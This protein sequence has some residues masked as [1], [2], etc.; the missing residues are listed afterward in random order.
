MHKIRLNYAFLLLAAWAAIFS[1]P[2]QAASWA[3][4]GSMAAARDSHTATLLLNGKV[5]V[6]GG[7]NSSTGNTTLA[8]TAL[9]DPA[10]GTWTAGTMLTARRLH[11]ATLLLN[12]KVLVAGGINDSGPRA[13]AALYDPASG[14]WATTGAMATPRVGPTATLLPNGKVLVAG[15][16]DSLDRLIASAEVYDPATGTWTT[17]GGMTT[18]RGSHTATLLANGKVLVAGG[19]TPIFSLTFASAEVYDPASGTWTAIDNMTR[20]R[21]GHTATRLPNG[22][23]LVAGGYQASAEIYD[24]ASGTWTA[25]GAMAEARDS[26]TATLLPN[27]KVLVA[28]GR[29]YPNSLASAAVYN[30][31]SGTWT[32]TAAMA[33]PRSSH[34]ATLL[35]NGKVL[36]AG[37]GNNTDHYLASAELYTPDAAPT[38]DFVVTGVTLTPTSPGVNTAFTAKVTVK[39]QGTGAGNGGNL[40]VWAD[41]GATQAC[42]VSGDKSVAVGTLAAGASKTLAVAGLT[43]SSAG[44]KTLRIFVDG[45]CI[46]LESDEG[47]N[48]LAAS[49]RAHGPPP[50]FIVSAVT[51][52]PASPAA[53]SLFTATVK[54]TNQGTLAADAGFLDVWG[55][56][57]TLQP[58]GADGDAWAAVGSVAAGASKTFT[59]TLQAGTAGAKTLRAFVDSWCATTESNEG[60]NQSNQAYTVK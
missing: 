38:A 20:A 36:V 28:G 60:N 49:Y 9:Y 33:G 23:L 32:A 44:L 18:G 54:I 40:L 53:N 30:P 35:T 4:T 5:L 2:A 37:G 6:A 48:Q 58:C 59:L 7:L 34:T 41:Q 17:T 42:G 8:S 12:G 51:L 21:A 57:P 29:N 16:S 3:A 11:T 1:L 27:G 22:K 31:A 56:Q 14:T 46:T 47:N 25:T 50:D 19:F 13:S 55:N 24:P 39:N 26:H 10:T 15:G 43:V 45:A 52:N